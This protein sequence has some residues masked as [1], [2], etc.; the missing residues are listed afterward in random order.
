VGSHSIT[1][2]L[3]AAGCYAI[4]KTPAVT[5]LVNEGCAAPV[6]DAG[7]PYSVVC[8]GAATTLA[9]DGS[10]SQAV[11][12]DDL[13]TFFWTTD[14]PNAAFDNAT[15]SQPTLVFG[16]SPGS[17]AQF[18]ATLAVSNGLH[19]ITR[20]VPVVVD[21][22]G[23]SGMG[24][25]SAC[26]V[27]SAAATCVNA[28][29]GE[30]WD[31]VFC[32]F[33]DGPTSVDAWSFDIDLINTVSGETIPIETA[34]AGEPLL[35]DETRTI[36]WPSGIV[37]GPEDDGK[38]Y[39]VEVSVR[40]GQAAEPA[41]RLFNNMAAT[42]FIVLGPTEVLLGLF[43]AEPVE[44]GLELR[45]QFGDPRA[46]TSV[47]L[48]RSDLASGPWMALETEHRMVEGVI[49]V[50]DATVEPERTYHYRLVATTSTGAKLVFG[51]L[52]ATAG[53]RIKEFALTRVAPNPTRGTTLV[54]FT[55]PRESSLRLSIIDVQG[56]EV[57]V[58]ATGRHRAGRYQAMWSGKS[59]QAAVA[60]GVYFVRYQGP[61]VNLVRRLALTR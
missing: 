4:S 10:G 56:R 60:P 25:K 15:S 26:V 51:P 57:T 32:V 29:E 36:Q 21:T 45:W 28:I 35:V 49:L 43:Q 24:V 20:T 47:V 23:V 1:A 16:S 27:D 11:G 8:N 48:E 12:P 14:H 7:G 22:C 18:N 19:T 9:M 54:E 53:A 50:L 38:N 33:N 5:Q 39:R 61:G 3:R 41:D 58:L 31:I 59:E 13:L 46:V 6:C 40:L 52:A 42:E 2:V 17:P 30:P 34:Q 44:T 55:V 37:F